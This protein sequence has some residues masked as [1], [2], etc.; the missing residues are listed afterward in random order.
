MEDARG[1]YVGLIDLKPIQVTWQVSS[2]GSIL[3]IL[4]GGICEYEEVMTAKFR[5]F[6]MPSVLLTD[7]TKFRERW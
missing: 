7:A 5:R 4:I 6:L 3:T 1:C 2:I